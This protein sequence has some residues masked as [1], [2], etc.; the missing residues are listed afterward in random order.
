MLFIAAW[1]F[2]TAF[3]VAG[4]VLAYGAFYQLSDFQLTAPNADPAMAQLIRVGGPVVVLTTGAL[5]LIAATLG[6][7]GWK[8]GRGFLLLAAILMLGIRAQTCATAWQA[9]T[10]A[11]AQS[12]SVTFFDP[13]W[14]LLAIANATV[15]SV[16]YPLLCIVAVFAARRSAN[17]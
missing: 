15:L 3:I 7:A 12:Q 6:R 9:A 8:A 4:F 11:V 14:H 1:V 10:A 13:T 2:A 16:A 5:L 17:C